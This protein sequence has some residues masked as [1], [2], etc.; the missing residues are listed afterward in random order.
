MTDINE[1]LARF[2]NTILTEASAEASALEQKQS[3]YHKRQLRLVEAEASTDAN[4]YYN[5]QKSRILAEAVRA[6]SQHKLE[7]KK[8]LALQ[9]ELMAQHVFARVSGLITEFT[10]SLD[11]HLWL[12]TKLTEILSKNTDCR[13]LQIDLRSEDFPLR[14]DLMAFTGGKDVLFREG[15]FRMGGLSV[16]FP[17]KKL[18]FDATFDTAF[19]ELEGHFSQLCKMPFSV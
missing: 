2:T 1:K 3:E 7:H 6:L 8:S 16:E 18:C 13:I 19:S 17:E 12:Q 15:A 4:A 10:Q 11:Y 5:M 9:R 14:S